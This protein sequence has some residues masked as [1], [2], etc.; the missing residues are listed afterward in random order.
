M[1]RIMGALLIVGMACSLASCK[2]IFGGVDS[3][4]METPA[5]NAPV[6][7]QPVIPMPSFSVGDSWEYSDGYGMSVVEAKEGGRARF[8]RTDV[9][10]TWFVQRAFFREESVSNGIH[11]F[12]VY[13]TADPI[14]LLEKPIGATVSYLREYMRNDELVRHRTSWEIEGRQTVTVPAGTFDVWVLVMRTE[15]VDSNWRGYERWFYSPQ[16]NSYVRMEY[17][18]GEAP[19]GSRVLMK[20][21][22][23]SASS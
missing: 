7:D 10:D 6:P 3:V 17:K 23:G 11:R 8:E 1:M 20:Y 4:T 5:T 2:T 22:M 13:R 9:S 19:D 21:S 18:Y 12:V 14:S 16:V 15:G